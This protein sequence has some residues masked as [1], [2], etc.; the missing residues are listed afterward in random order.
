[1]SPTNVTAVRK[2]STA[3][4]LLLSMYLKKLRKLKL[5]EKGLEDALQRLEEENGF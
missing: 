1:M 4:A 5:E 2:N 3:L